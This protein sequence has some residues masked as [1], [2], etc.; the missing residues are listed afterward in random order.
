MLYRHPN[1]NSRARSQVA[2]DLQHA[3]QDSPAFDSGGVS[4]LRVVG[5]ALKLP[6]DV[7]DELTTKARQLPVY[8]ITLLS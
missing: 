2:V 4:G 1:F 3:P 5:G 6:D 7:V 8:R